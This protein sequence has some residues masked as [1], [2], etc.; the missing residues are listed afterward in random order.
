MSDEEKKLTKCDCYRIAAKFLLLTTSVFLGTLLAII[1]AAHLL[2]PPVPPCNCHH[3]GMHKMP[4]KMERFDRQL[5]PTGVVKH[6][7]GA[8]IYRVENRLPQKDFKRAHQKNLQNG[9]KKDFN[10]MKQRGMRPDFKKG[11][12]PQRGERPQ[13]PQPKVPEMPVNQ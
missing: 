9:T 7:K 13:I 8:K 3:R 12:F 6:Q 1:F 5:P 2:K 10:N 11:Q 4:P